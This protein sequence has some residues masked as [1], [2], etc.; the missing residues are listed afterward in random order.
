MTESP[1]SSK[2]PKRNGSWWRKNWFYTVLIAVALLGGLGAFWIPFR[3]PQPFSKGDSIS[4]LRQSILAATGGILAILT[5]WE[6]RRKNIQEKEKND[7]DHTRQVHAERRSR[8]AKAIEQLA[9]EKAPIRLG[10]IYTLVKLVDEWL[11]D[12]KTLPNEEERRE[13]GQVIVNSLCAYIRSPFDLVPKAEVLSQDQTPENYEGG[14]QQFVKDRARFREEQ[15]IR[16]IILSEI[17]KRLNGDKVK[18]KEITQI[19][20]GT[21]SYFEYNFSDAHFFYAVNFNNSY[22]GASLNF[23]GA[24]FTGYVNFSGATFTQVIFSGATFTRRTDFSGAT[25]T[26]RTDFSGATFTRRTDFSGATFTQVIFFGA[27]FTHDADFTM[28]AFTHDADF[29]WVT[30]THDADFTSVTFTGEASF[31]MATFTGYAN[32]SGATFT[33]DAD[34]SSATFTGEASFLQ[35]ADFRRVTFHGEPSFIGVLGKARFSYKVIPEDYRFEVDP[36]SP[37]KIETEEQEYNG[38]KFRIPKGATLFD[39][40]EPSEQKDDNDS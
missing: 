20:P 21:W 27:T 10:G 31:I 7:Q 15:E 39:P 11:A 17:K 18:N 14:D 28:A 1:K 30:F 23:L 19:T 29:R 9:D 2:T 25:F 8:Y 24:T 40:D 34:F 22:F 33:H 5:L 36:D 16:H 26:R 6:N 3:L 32:F 13:E 38:V 12:E 35:G 4:T 37:C